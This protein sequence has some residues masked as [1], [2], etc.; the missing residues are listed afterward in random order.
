MAELR[1][2]PDHVVGTL[3][4]AAPFD[5]GTGPT[6]ASGVVTVPD[7]IGVHLEVQSLVGSRRMGGG[8]WELLPDHRPIDLEFLRV[9]P[10]NV[11]GSI[12][13][14][15]DVVESSVS[16]LAHLAPGLTSLYL[17]WSNLTDAVLPHVA[18]LT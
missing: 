4:W 13:L 10:T 3:D 5:A 11:I 7:G 1:F 17:P 6:P 14:T 16:A 8:G 12:S 18:G 9:L 15:R 2:P